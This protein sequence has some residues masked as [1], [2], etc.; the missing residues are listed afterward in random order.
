MRENPR[1]R[2]V[3][4]RRGGRGSVEGRVR[5]RPGGQGMQDRINIGLALSRV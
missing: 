4:V 3:S 2:K 5:A 1:V